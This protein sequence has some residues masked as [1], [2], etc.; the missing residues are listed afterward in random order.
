MRITVFIALVAL[1]STSF[2]K[3]DWTKVC[4]NGTCSYD[5]EEGESNMGGRFDISGSPSAISDITSAAGWSI[6]N[7]TDST[8]SQTIKIVCTDESKGCGHI[9]QNGAQD[10]IIRLPENCGSGPF[11]RVAKHWI[12]DDQSIPKALAAN[13]TSST[14]TMPHVHML[15]I[16][17]N[18]DKAS[19]IHGNVSFEL[20]TQGNLHPSPKQQKR[21]NGSGST[22][23]PFSLVNENVI[24][25]D[26]MMTCPVASG[27]QNE[28]FLGSLL[29]QN[30]T[31][32]TTI[33]VISSG[34]LVPPSISSL[35]FSA[36]MNGIVDGAGLASLSLQG[37]ISV[38]DFQFLDMIFASFSI[39]DVV[40]VQPSFSIIANAA[41]TVE[42][43][44]NFVPFVGF[45]YSITNLNFTYP[46]E[47]P[48]PSVEVTT[49]VS[50]F[51]VPA[52]PSE[53]SN[54]QITMNTTFKF[55]VQVNAF[56]QTV[57]L[58]VSYNVAENMSMNSTPAVE[59]EE[60]VCFDLDNRFSLVVANSG[61]FFQAFE[62][63]GAQTIFEDEI[64]ILSICDVV[65]LGPSPPSRRS[66][67]PG[68]PNTNLKRDI[69]SCPPVAATS[70]E[71]INIEGTFPLS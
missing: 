10:T 5:V 64:P 34:T 19:G 9:F 8:N 57:D 65:E 1:S 58:S 56:G 39:A 7:C 70:L 21:Q 13:H 47:V 63:P 20:R 18:F 31:L 12:P 26:D 42:G 54:A 51:N 25:F 2:G 68:L 43:I 28:I 6:V 22:V 3:N 50:Q 15:E 53:N 35:S 4:L 32:E 29:I 46:F 11:V 71:V 30:V 17:G 69:F 33:I 66:N 52:L 48:A 36:P 14:S 16:D 37:T 45:A 44:T 23:A 38:I 61:P 55:L 62:A 59:G 24:I 60:V 67:T 27:Q 40:T 49:P 41:G